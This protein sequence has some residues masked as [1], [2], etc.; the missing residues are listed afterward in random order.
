[1]GIASGIG[2]QVGLA[3]EATYGTY[4]A[5]TR[6]LQADKVSLKKVKNTVQ[7][8]GFASG[9][10]MQ[11]ASGRVVTT[12]AA[13]GTLNSEILNRGMGLLIQALMGTSVTP[14]QQGATTAYLQTH[15]LADTL[16]KSLT[17]QSGIP[18]RAGVVHPYSYLGCKVTGADFSWDLAKDATAAFTIDARDVDET[19]T[20]AAASYSAGARPFV[21]TD[22]TIKVGTYGSEASVSGVTKAD[23]KFD[24]GHKLDSFYFGANGLKAEPVINAWP[25]IGGTITAEFVDKTVWADRFA[26]DTSFSLVLEAVGLPIGTSGSNDTFRITLPTCFL[27]GDT[28]M[29]D[30]LDVISGQFPFVCL[31]DDAADLPK[32]EIISADTTL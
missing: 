25:K 30:T 32:I 17:I 12:H 22:V 11:L 27:D 29:A 4:V 2:S 26:A 8:A 10:L 6:F 23:V 1:M 28:P 19:P 3:A 14:V 21:G 7:S 15:T 16:G 5:P 20:L 24:R 9:R 31:L 13:S 18:D